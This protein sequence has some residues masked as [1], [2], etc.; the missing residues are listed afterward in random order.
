MLINLLKAL[1]VRW[2]TV[3]Q[4]RFTV[5]ESEKLKRLTEQQDQD[6]ETSG[7]ARESENTVVNEKRK[8]FFFQISQWQQV[9]HVGNAVRMVLLVVGLWYL[10]N[11]MLPAFHMLG[12][13]VLW[14]ASQNEAVTLEAA[15]MA[16]TVL[17][18]TAVVARNV[19]G[20]LEIFILR[21][22]PIDRGMRFAVTTICRYIL[23]IIGTAFAF[24]QI[25][26]GWSKIQW[27]VA[28]MTVGLAF[29]LQ[30]I[31]ANFVSGLIILLDQPI[32]V[33]D[34]VTVGDVTGRVTRIK[35]RAT[36]L[37]QWD[38][39]ELI[40]PN[41]E[42]IT[43]RLVNWTLSDSILRR[44]FSVGVAYGS[45]IHKAEKILYEIATANPKIID[46]P[47]PVVIFTGF[48]DSTLDFVLRVYI[49]GVENIVPVWHGVNCAIDDAFRKAN[50]T[51]AFP[52]RELHL[53]TVDANIE[54]MLKDNS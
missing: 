29:G 10:W 15:A 33:D 9:L 26:F 1:F 49:S 50:I 47:K 24:G 8:Q 7:L 5:Q 19:P 35:I 3:A 16:L 13:S 51:I 44:E 2:L 46:D 20:L 6:K 12:E 21:R 18:L 30:E 41:K 53:H 43:G 27:L 37:R 40:V 38:E 36:T 48:G 4:H 34:I 32:R 54:N 42:F 22:L 52:Q 14:S 25:G 39:R 11:D 23:V 17:I 45:D 31:F 28:A